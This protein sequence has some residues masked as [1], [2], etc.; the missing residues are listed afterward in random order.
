MTVPILRRFAP[1]GEVEHLWRLCWQRECNSARACPVCH[2]TM[3]AFEVDLPDK[4]IEMNTCRQ[5]QMF[6]YDATQ[7]GEVPRD[8]MQATGTLSPR[9]RREYD[10]ARLNALR[11]RLRMAQNDHDAVRDPDVMWW[12]RDV[13][14]YF[15]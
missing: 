5:C 2:H 12:A 4:P 3:V 15:V 8:I 9:A 10:E 6:F 14:H 1:P 11:D 7:L 13:L